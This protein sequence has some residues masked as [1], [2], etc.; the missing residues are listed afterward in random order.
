MAFRS[1]FGPDQRGSCLQQSEPRGGE[2]LH[3]LGSKAGR[4][5]L[6]PL[7][8]VKMFIGDSLGRG[9]GKAQ[10]SMGFRN[11][12]TPSGVRRDNNDVIVSAAVLP[13]HTHHRNTE[14]RLEY[15]ADRVG[16]KLLPHQA[17]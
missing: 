6:R 3:T 2:D 5:N 15:F 4:V 10:F 12:N 9:H 16:W 7:W 13:I 1:Q 8:S 14:P 11:M 17:G